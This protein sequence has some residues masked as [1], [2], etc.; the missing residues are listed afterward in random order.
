V[1]LGKRGDNEEHFN[2]GRR[3][4]WI[5]EKGGER[6]ELLEKGGKV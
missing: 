1:L 4:V 5:L 3:Q 2:K 6:G